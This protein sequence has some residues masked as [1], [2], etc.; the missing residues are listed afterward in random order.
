M[1]TIFIFKTDKIKKNKNF[2]FQKEKWQKMK[3]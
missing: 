1:Y 2:K 3:E